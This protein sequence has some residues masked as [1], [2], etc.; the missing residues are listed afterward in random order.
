MSNLSTDDQ[1]DD[2]TPDRK[3]WERCDYPYFEIQVQ[4]WSVAKLIALKSEIT[5]TITLVITQIETRG[6]EDFEWWKKARA[7]RGF[8][9]QKQ[10]LLK[11]LIGA[12]NLKAREQKQL[13]KKERI[14]KHDGYM[15]ERGSL[16]QRA[17]IQVNQGDLRGALLSVLD[18]LELNNE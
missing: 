16:L 7:A 3:W 5:T 8:M 13:R 4:G 18:M 14:E 17:R 15:T 10:S 9:Q 11:Q 2:D 12:G 6:K 1:K